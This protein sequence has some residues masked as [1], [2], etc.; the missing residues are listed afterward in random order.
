MIQK[1]KK[2]H[3]EGNDDV[4]AA[5]EDFLHCNGVDAGRVARLGVFQQVM[6]GVSAGV[7]VPVAEA[8]VLSSDSPPVK[9]LH[10]SRCYA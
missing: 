8:E 2:N 5:P 4:V 7:Y 1:K 10:P 6:N 9:R 3:Q